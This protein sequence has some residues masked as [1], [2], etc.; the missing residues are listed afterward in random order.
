LV[1]YP[2]TTTFVQ[3]GE[4]LAIVLRVLQRPD[5]QSVAQVAAANDCSPAHVYD[6]V[7]RC[8]GAML[9]RRPGPDPE[10]RKILRLE[11]RV[12]EFEA[13][14]TRDHARIADLERRLDGAVQLDPRRLARLEV[15]MAANNV[16]APKSLS[17]RWPHPTDRSGRHW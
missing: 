7:A 9:P 17:R 1:S 6:L 5:D 14:R 15:V 10:A 13:E 4:P 3:P 12:A 16:T 11:A 2:L 8:R